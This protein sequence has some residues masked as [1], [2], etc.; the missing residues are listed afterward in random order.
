MRPT[1]SYSSLF[2]QEMTLAQTTLAWS[3]ASPT[4]SPGLFYISLVPRGPSWCWMI[5][6]PNSSEFRREEQL[7]F[8]RL[9]KEASGHLL[10][11]PIG[12]LRQRPLSRSD[13][14]RPPEP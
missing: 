11:S 14:Q 8:G 6:S 9:G 3:L 1:S 7:G 4:R 13:A 5:H 10:F 2:S 12:L